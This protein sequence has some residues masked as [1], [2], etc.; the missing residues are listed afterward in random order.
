LG[1]DRN[2]LAEDGEAGPEERKADEGAPDLGEAKR[3]IWGDTGGLNK[4]EL[5]E[6]LTSAQAHR[7]QT[8][9]PREKD[10]R[11]CEIFLSTASSSGERT[12]ELC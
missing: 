3:V 5:S 10:D 2:C 4:I 12:Q 6:S 7:R 11:G 9:A 8:S 1:F